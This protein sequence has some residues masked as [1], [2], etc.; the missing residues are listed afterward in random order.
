M[1]L[2]KGIEGPGQHQAGGFVTLLCVG[3]AVRGWGFPQAEVGGRSREL[4]CHMIHE[5]RQPSQYPQPGPRGSLCTAAPK[6][7]DL[8]FCTV[9]ARHS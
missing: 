1:S 4:T 6:L 5:L 2:L 8:W 9:A 7:S 3:F